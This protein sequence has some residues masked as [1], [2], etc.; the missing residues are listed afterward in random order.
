MSRPHIIILG[1]GFGG[2][3][4][5]KALAHFVRENKIDV[6]IINKSNNFLFTPLLHEVATGALSPRIVAE[7][8]REIFVGTNV[9]IIQGNAISINSGSRSVTV[10]HNKVT[11]VFNYDY[12]VVATGAETNYYG[13]PGAAEHAL[14]LKSIVEAR[15]IRNHI[16][17]AFE[18]AM[19]VADREARKKHLSFVVVG[20]GATGVEVV[21][22]LAEF[23]EGMVS[24]YYGTTNCR[25][26]DEHACR[27]EEPRITLIHAGKELLEQF[28][29]SLRAAAR[30]RLEQHGVR[31]MLNTAVTSV[32]EDSINVSPVGNPTSQ[33]TLDGSVV[34]WSAG[35]KAIIPRFEDITPALEKGRIVTDA[36]LAMKDHGNIFVLGDAAITPTPYPQL[37]QMAARQARTVAENIIRAIDGQP[38]VDF[39]YTSMGSMV[40]VGQWFAIGEILSLSIAG[41]LAWWIWR[42]V[43]LF[44]FA[45]YKKRIRIAFEWALEMFFPRDITKGS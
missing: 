36:A 21:A 16:I 30:K 22:E 18:T 24:R 41:R 31:I 27:N 25:E 34:I 19:L 37:A 39:S 17:D 12:L 45:S 35:V 11:H 32:G 43:Y 14:P 2:V 44:K 6:T 20:G 29:P 8:L 15:A 38:R 28:K 4:V 33:E 7:S 10:E 40:S 1:A 13:I 5:G 9:R 42:T 26:G 23:V 3:Y